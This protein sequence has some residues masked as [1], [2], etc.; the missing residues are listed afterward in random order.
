MKVF[1]VGYGRVNQL[2]HQK[3]KH[4][5]VGVCDLNNNYISDKPDLIIDFSNPKALD[6]TI[7][8]SLKYN[9]KVLIGTTG[10]NKKELS[11]IKELSKKVPV[12]LISNFSLG[13]MLINK[14]LKENGKYFIDYDKHI[15]EIH[16]KNKVDS[17][18]GTAKT[19]ARYI[20][21]KNITSIRS[22]DVIGVHE[23]ILIN[24]DEIINIKH[25]ITSRNNYIN[26]VL[27][28]IEWLSNK[29]KGMY[30]LEDLID[31]I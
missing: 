12:L 15:I 29:E 30:S 1:L 14:F 8:L 22:K 23:L 2:I 24:D 11:K 31:E 16:H 26:G 28:A 20:D 18:S 4:S 3:I 25:S 17:P 10:Y 5:I 6:F 7:E 13:M 27:K 9:S 21:C 19:M